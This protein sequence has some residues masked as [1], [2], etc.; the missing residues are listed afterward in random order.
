MRRTV[1]LGLAAM[2]LFVLLTAIETLQG[3][4]PITLS[5]FAS[6]LLE[7]SVLTVAVLATSFFSFE[8]RQIRK[9][10]AE[11]R[12]DL[13]HARAESDLWRSAAREHLDGLA[14]AI[15]GQFTKWGLTD[16]EKDVAA[17]MLKGLAHKE[18]A[19]MRHTS[20]A[21]VRQQASAIYVKSGLSSRAEFSAYFLEDLFPPRQSE[22]SGP[23][24]PRA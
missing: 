10:Y 1:L 13:A 18:I 9:D 7:T 17:L 24:Q 5:S 23:G 15:Q 16:A 8:V 11:L 19:N 3:D 12:E 20:E 21:T 14:S 6:D 22:S 4:G 2:F